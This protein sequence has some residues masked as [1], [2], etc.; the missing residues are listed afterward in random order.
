MEHD[1]TRD[2]RR[3]SQIT[4][5]V[6][7]L[8]FIVLG[9]VVRLAA[10]R[11]G[12]CY[13]LAP[14]SY[15]SIAT[16]IVEG[17][18]FLDEMSNFQVPDRTR[19]PPLVPALIAA[20]MMVFGKASGVAAFLALQAFLSA[21]TAVL[22]GLIGRRISGNRNLFFFL[23][24]IYAAWGP[25]IELSRCAM[26]EL[27]FIFLFAACLLALFTAF[28]KPH[29][30]L[31]ATAGALMGLASLT[32]PLLYP[33][34]GLLALSWPWLFAKSVRIDRRKKLLTAVA[35]YGAL[36]VVIAPWIVRNTT[37]NGRPTL[38]T[39]SIGL[40]LLMQ[41][42]PVD[43]PEVWKYAVRESKPGGELHGMNEAQRDRYLMDRALR[44][45]REDFTTF[46][47]N[48]ILRIR[49]IYDSPMYNFPDLTVPIRW[50][51]YGWMLLILG[52][53]L[54]LRGQPTKG[55]LVVL[56]LLNFNIVYSLT[57]FEARFRETVM[58][59]MMPLAGMGIVFLW[60]K[61]VRYIQKKKAE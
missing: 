51:H 54:L 59:L 25:A 52:L 32:R 56:L 18:G 50:W 36:L 39:S 33:A 1:S 46:L 40:N 16:N 60:R 2:N 15:I 24:A 12:T 19:R 5:V 44:Y 9:F 29:I 34:Y 17:D 35:F 10:S 49:L 37:L 28:E 42:A 45:I 7:A 23:T 55:L 20:C 27:T 13:W 53:V 61:A 41:N 22:I 26:T 11:T 30:G 21:V 31:F 4:L 58:P 38:I 57:F 6:F 8:I 48:A 3:R 47:G 43:Q 14:Q